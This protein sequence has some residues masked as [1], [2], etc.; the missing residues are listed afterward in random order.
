MKPIQLPGPMNCIIVLQLG[1]HL[2]LNVS[3]AFADIGAII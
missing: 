1:F 3:L 2:P